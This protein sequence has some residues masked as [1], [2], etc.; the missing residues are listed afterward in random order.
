M[1]DSPK[2]IIIGVFSFITIIFLGLIILFNAGL[3]V[4]DPGITDKQFTTMIIE[5]HSKLPQPSVLYLNVTESQIN[6]S[7]ILKTTCQE[8]IDSNQES[9]EV[10]LNSSEFNCVTSFLES[11][12]TKG[13]DI[14]WIYYQEFFF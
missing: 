7:M 12:S 8:L 14:S 2:I 1:Q 10:Q 9:I 11:F 3:P 6:R 13:T 5:K 4:I